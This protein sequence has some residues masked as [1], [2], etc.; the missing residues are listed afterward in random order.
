MYT[1]N[2][3]AV[4]DGGGK[5]IMM[6][7]TIWII[8]PTDIKITSSWDPPCNIQIQEES[9]IQEYDYQVINLD[10][11]VSAAAKRRR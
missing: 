1:T 2:L 7:G 10:T 9:G 6:D 8:N 5:L 3:M 11:S 4:Q